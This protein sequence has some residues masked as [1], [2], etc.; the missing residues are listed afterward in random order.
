[1]TSSLLR[2]RRILAVE[3]EY[4][5]AMSLEGDLTA[6]GVHVLGPVPSIEQAL[7]L[8]AS[9]PDIDAAV[10]DLNLGGEM[11]FPVADALAARAIPFVIT[12]GYVDGD[13][14]KRYPHITRC[15]KP[16]DTKQLLAALEAT[17]A[18]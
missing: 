16:V 15:E 3:D 8:I 10:L 1:M 17:L 4:Y 11:S 14:D 5:L 9:E 2:D 18:G 13:L 7:S 12:T 6:A